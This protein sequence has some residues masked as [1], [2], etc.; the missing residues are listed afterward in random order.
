MTDFDRPADAAASPPPDPTIDTT[1][2][3]TPTTPIGDPAGVLTPAAAAT[4]GVATTGKRRGAG[5]W[6]AAIGVIAVV[7]ALTAVVSFALTGAS[8]NATVLGYVPE[9]SVMYGEV[10]LD[11]PGDQR[12]AVGEFLS[13]FPGFADQAALETK[14]DEVLDELVSSAT[15][16]EQT[17]SADIKPWFDGELAFAI[18]PIPSDIDVDDPE[19]MSSEARAL[20][21]LSIKDATLASAWFADTMSEAG[22]SGT[23]EAYNGTDI[24]VFADAEVAAAQAAFAIVG[25]EVAVAG[26]LTSVKAAIDTGGDG[27][28]EDTEGFAAAL[29]ATPTDHIGFMYV[30]TRSFLD[31]ALGVAESGGASAPI[32]T[33]FLDLVPAWT[34]AQLRIEGDAVVMDAATPHVDGAPGPAENGTNAVAG[35]APADTF[36]LAA[37]ND[38]GA[39]LNEAI[40]LYGGDPSMSEALDELEG[41]LGILGGMDAV[42]DWMGDAGLVVSGS[43]ESITGG[44]IV[45]PNDPE[46]AAQLFTTIR[47]LITLAGSEAGFTVREET[48][49]GVTVVIVDLGSAEDLMGL[50]SALGGGAI[51]EAPVGELP[52]GNVELSWAV[53]DEVV[54]I[55]AGPDFVAAAL[56]ASNGESLADTDRYQ[57]LVARVGAEHTGVTFIDIAAIRT[58]VE[59]F[60]DEATAEERAEY[61]ESVK[62]YLEPLDAFIA[63]SVVGGDLDTQHAIITVK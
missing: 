62:P 19:A 7:G 31:A 3:P 59:G 44:L 29:A 14:L 20:A 33:A 6:I 56:A 42:I 16:G 25:G 38:V 48:I 34:G 61:E 36:L 54:I 9:D 50:G 35:H 58:V 37:G 23:V 63:A 8:P 52:E 26:D 32:P 46:A 41:A 4:A 1:V 57:D 5:R 10:R 12:Q 21:L 24:T 45:E 55:G 13:H 51:P 39:T 18:G 47:S 28:L 40:E 15:D 30:D 22:V 49:E 2:G 43:G 60:L 27:G 53:T 17:F 11:L